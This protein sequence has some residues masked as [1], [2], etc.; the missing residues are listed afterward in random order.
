MATPYLQLRRD[1]V[2]STQDLAR[3]ELDRLPTVVIAERQ[4]AGRGRTGATWLTAPRALAA[5]VSFLMDVGD[6][7][8]LSLMAGLAAIRVVADVSLKWPNDVVAGDEKLGGI[9]VERSGHVVVA[10]IGLNLWWPDAPEGVG[11]LHGSDPGRD[12][13]AVIGGLWA[14]ELLRLVEGSGWPVD[15]YRAACVTLGREITWEPDGR[16]TA[17][18]VDEEGELIVEQ[19]GQRR[20]LNSG[21]IRHLRPQP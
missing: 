8:P 16:G 9:L 18:D 12:L 5:S 17:V 20:S 14:A 19:G 2:P 13:H 11:A 3:S 1:E 15:E 21:V 10:G 7:R 4:T 6:R